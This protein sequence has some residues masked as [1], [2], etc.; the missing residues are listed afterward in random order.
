MWVGCCGLRHHLQ[1]HAV[2]DAGGSLQLGDGREA[3]AMGSPPRM[4]DGAHR[5]VH[6]ATGQW[7]G[8]WYAQDSVVRQTT[9]AHNALRCVCY[10]VASWIASHGALHVL[11]PGCRWTMSTVHKRPL[12]CP[13]G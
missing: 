2:L 9:E 13:Q 3:A 1:R 10:A 4:L 11:P 5:M 6:A 8:L 12:T 7:H